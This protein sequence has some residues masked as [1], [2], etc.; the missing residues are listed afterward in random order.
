MPSPLR[1]A[2][3]TAP[4]ESRPSERSPRTWS[5]L[6][7]AVLDDDAIEPLVGV[8]EVGL[9]V[10]G[11]V[12]HGQGD[13]LVGLA[14][15]PEGAVAVAQQDQHV[16]EEVADQQVGDAVAVDVGEVRPAASAATSVAMRT[17]ARHGHR[18]GRRMPRIGEDGDV[19][20]AVVI[21]V[22]G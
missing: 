7:A 16:A 20:H 21:E 17:S 9:A 13:G 4:G 14:V 3:L 1:S 8:D 6:V 22:A 5:A 19:G 10:A 2:S 18:R 15:G 11:E 12:G